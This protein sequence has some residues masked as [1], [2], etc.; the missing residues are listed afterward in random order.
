[1]YYLYE[2]DYK[3]IDW[4]TWEEKDNTLEN[5]K[6]YVL[7]AM[8]KA[9]SN[10]IFPYQGYQLLCE[11]GAEEFWK[12]FYKTYLDTTYEWSWQ[13]IEKLLIS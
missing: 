12:Y 2:T 5:K 3:I 6:A 10:D 9:I 8:D 13:K 1:M 7:V 4:E 11:L